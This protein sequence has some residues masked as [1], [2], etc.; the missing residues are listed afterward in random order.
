MSYDDMT[1]TE[2]KDLAKERGMTGYSS[3]LKDQLIEALDISDAAV[4]DE[5]AKE[6]AE[7]KTPDPAPTKKPRPARKTHPKKIPACQ[8]IGC[9]DGTYVDPQGDERDCPFCHP[10]EVPKGYHKLAKERAAKAS[11]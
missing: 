9:S 4:A 6:A 5:A 8:R 11:A 3:L 10:V 2:L 1:V 7:S